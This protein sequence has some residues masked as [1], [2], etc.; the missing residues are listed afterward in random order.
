MYPS[1]DILENLPCGCLIFDDDGH[2]LYANPHLCAILECN[3]YDIENKV[4]ESI[5]TISSS[6]FYQTHFFPLLKLKGEVS[7]IFM[8]LKSKT[9]KRVPVMINAQQS[10][11]DAMHHYIASV[12]TV[13][14][15]QKY[16]Q[17]LLEA[18]KA[19][20]KA[21]EDNA[22][23]KQLKAELEQHQRKLDRNL[24]VV[25]E[26][27]AEYLQIGKVL[28]HDM[29]EPIRKISLCFDSLISQTELGNNSKINH[30]VGIIKKSANRLH[31][32]TNALNDFVNFGSRD[33]RTEEINLTKLIE[34]VR[35]ELEEFYSDNYTVTIGIT[36][37]FWG[38]R[39][40]IKRVFTE[41]FKNSI[42]NQTPGLPLSI[43]IHAV[44]IEE[45]SYQVS[46]QKYHYTDHLRI[47]VTD[48]GQGFENQ[49]AEYVFGLL[50][51]LKDREE[52]LGIGLT[53]CKQIIQQHRGTMNIKTSPGNGTTAIIVLPVSRP[54][55][56]ES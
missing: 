55:E 31:T 53:I 56:V 33:Q 20:K 46:S 17:E 1:K 29:Q 8:T 25:M 4:M 45:N 12:A 43:N 47:E 41:L 16:E 15:R 54:K 21:L 38:V 11:Q 50:N 18:T 7:E 37:S 28:T 49:Y 52:C 42:Q 40:Q 30:M 6:I 27:N 32:L 34:E 22:L 24:S 51:K 48:N 35:L 10:D 13:W 36:P 26:R 2:I 44:N 19:Q 5:L 23:L 3:F 39:L 9:G 14:E